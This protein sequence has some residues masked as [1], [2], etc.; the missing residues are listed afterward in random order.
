MPLSILFCAL[1]LT[2][3]LF[4]KLIQLLGLDNEFYWFE[5]ASNASIQALLA[6]FTLR[7][8]FQF[9]GR[10]QQQRKQREWIFFQTGI[11]VFGI[12]LLLML[13]QAL[14]NLHNQPDLTLLLVKAGLFALISSVAVA[15][16]V[17]YP[18]ANRFNRFFNILQIRY[19]T[20]YLFGVALLLSLF[21][22]IYLHQKAEYEAEVIA[23]EAD[24]L[25]L[26]DKALTYRIAETVLDTLALASQPDF[27]R[28]LQGDTRS[29]DE[30]ELE[31]ENSVRI[32][33]SYDQIRF[34]DADGQEQVRVNRGQHS[35]EIVP[36]QELQNKRNRYYVPETG[37]LDHGK[38][39]ISPLD[40]NIEYGKIETPYKPITRISTPVKDTANNLMGLIVINLNASHL[41]QH[42]DDAEAL[43]QGKVMMVNQQGFWLYDSNPTRMWSFMFEADSEHNMASAQP[44]LWQAISDQATGVLKNDQGIFVFHKVFLNQSPRIAQFQQDPY[45]WPHWTL[46]TY[47]PNEIISAGSLQ[48]FQLFTVFCTLL[49]MVTGIGT[50]LYTLS[51]LKRTNAEQKV[52]HMAVHDPLTGL[53]N[54]RYLMDQLDQLLADK[55]HPERQLALFYLDLDNFKPIND[56]L[57]H[58]AGD[59]VLKQVSHRLSQMLRNTDVLARI[60]GDEFVILIK[61]PHSLEHLEEIAERIIAQLSRNV[62]INQFSCKLGV[63]I[64]ITVCSPGEC[65]R[66]KILKAADMLMLEAKAE[67]KAC[68][69]LATATQLAEP[70]KRKAQQAQTAKEKTE[71]A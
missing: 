46:I 28:H 5:A 39:Y 51:Q 65:T 23:H 56:Q 66:D 9:C 15:V 57:G 69:R 22:N 30:V 24:Q 32:K 55:Q 7:L 36:P 52:Q 11:S 53:Y 16:Y 41:L 13:L 21:S 59:D 64:G 19:F 3:L 26:I 54:R 47:L 1:F 42:L 33:K 27:V 12:E 58:E 6:L 68:Y 37:K 31:F 49:L 2:E 17:L 14:F 34:I 4:S 63:S 8:I 61:D 29:L 18:Q 48:R 62:Q 40:L 71:P 20:S 10:S 35:V 25:T 67:G 70:Q 43:S 38:V 45:I 60:G 50:Y 44:A